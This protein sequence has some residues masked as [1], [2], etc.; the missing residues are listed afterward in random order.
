MSVNANESIQPDIM[1]HW[2]LQALLGDYPVVH[3]L[4]VAG[5]NIAER[6]NDTVDIL[7][8]IGAYRNDISEQL[9]EHDLMLNA[10]KDVLENYGDIRE[11]IYSVFEMLILKQA[12]EKV[13]EGTV[14]EK[15]KTSC[16]Q[17]LKNMML[18]FEDISGLEEQKS[19][20]IE[21]DV[22]YT[23]PED[24]SETVE[25]L[26]PLDIVD[27]SVGEIIDDDPAP[28]PNPPENDKEEPVSK[29]GESYSF[30]A[31]KEGEQG[32]TVLIPVFNVEQYILRTLESVRL[33]T[34]QPKVILRDDK[35][36]DGTVEKIKAYLKQHKLE[37]TLIEGDENLGVNISRALLAEAAITSH[38][39]FVDDD[40][41]FIRKNAIE[42]LAEYLD[43]D[44]IAF[45]IESSRIM[46]LE[47]TMPHPAA[48]KPII[49]SLIARDFIGRPSFVYRKI[50]FSNFVWYRYHNY[51]EDYFMNLAFLLKNPKEYICPDI[52]YHWSQRHGSLSEQSTLEAQYKSIGF[53]RKQAKKLLLESEWFKKDKEY[54]IS[55]MRGNV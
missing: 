3:S 35:S 36:T 4:K 20:I 42:T 54:A 8:N 55:V 5:Y 13:P 18:D 40:D 9:Y 19:N 11:Y 22:S 28:P 39:I 48:D 29:F 44:L 49:E 7:V 27:D 17:T 30:V 53:Y 1:E 46:T 38:V 47:D 33:Q 45:G 14:A 10:P 52:L 15:I 50:F 25:A 41:Y 24:I 23:D 34:L 12:G 21:E 31:D 37:W 51:S 16:P 26:A 2:N 43:N 6:D 32:I